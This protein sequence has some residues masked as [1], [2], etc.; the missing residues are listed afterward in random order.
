MKHQEV[1]IY[2]C[3]GEGSPGKTGEIESED[4]EKEKNNLAILNPLKQ[5]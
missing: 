2:V 3:Y 4:P 5:V 1:L